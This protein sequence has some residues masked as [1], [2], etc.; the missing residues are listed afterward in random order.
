MT[1]FLIFLLACSFVMILLCSQ[2]SQ[3]LLNKYP[4]TIDCSL[5]TADQTPEEL[6][7]GALIEWTSLTSAEEKG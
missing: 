7:A 1:F 6:L 2:S 4:S 3:K 5:V